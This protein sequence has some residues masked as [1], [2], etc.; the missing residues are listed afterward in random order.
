MLRRSVTTVLVLLLGSALLPLVAAAPAGAAEPCLSEARVSLLDPGCDDVTPPDTAI[1]ATAPRVTPA[2]WINKRTLRV[3]LIGIHADADADPISFDCSLG[4]DPVPPTEAGWA[5]CPEGNV[6][7]GL[8]PSA[9]PYVLWARAVDSADAAI[10]WSD[11]NLL[12]G[13]VDEAVEDHDPTPAKLTFRVDTVAPDTLLSGGPT[14][15]LS[16]GL[17]MLRTPRTT[18]RL[19]A[20]EASSFR[21]TLNGVALP[22]AAGP[23]TVRPGTSGVQ[24]LEVQAVD[25]AGNVDPTPATLR[26]VVPVDLGAPR[27]GW[28]RVRSR[29]SLGGSLLLA[30][31]RGSALQVR[32]GRYGELWLL[33]ATGPRAGAVEVRT[34]RTWTRVSLR[35]PTGRAADRVRVRD[36]GAPLLRGPIRIRVVSRG[37]PVR[38]DGV[39]AP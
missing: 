15:R 38:L 4:H 7:R 3:G 21:C 16:L 12:N 32:P 26:F 31:E 27:R 20:S 14:D 10:R 2:G 9:T 6:F 36:A 17:P 28:T 8:V 19:A 11:N 22:C 29:G 30:R 1:G 25:P 5:P 37:R 13:L 18:V 23:L 35:R 34:G 24:A 33:A 39:L